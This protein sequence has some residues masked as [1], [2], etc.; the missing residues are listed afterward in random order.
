MRSAV[1]AASHKCRTRESRRGLAVLLKLPRRQRDAKMRFLR[2]IRAVIMSAGGV[3]VGGM[4]GV[5]DLA[6]F[7]T[8]CCVGLAG[9]LCAHAGNEEGEREARGRSLSG[10][11]KALLQW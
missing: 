2:I 8:V 4:T 9:G 3:R 1:L 6:H 10:G 11:I 7:L 5:R